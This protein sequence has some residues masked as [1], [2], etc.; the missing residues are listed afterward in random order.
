MSVR[1]LLDTNV[2][3]E[4]ARPRPHAGVMSALEANRA[5]VCTVAVVA[6]EL[7]YGVARLPAG[8]RRRQLEA[9]VDAV[10][11]SSLPVLPY[12][13][14]AAV[15]HA[16]QRAANEV[17]GQ[18]VGFADGIVAAVAAVNGLTVVTRDHTG[19]VAFDVPVISWWS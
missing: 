8:R 14:Q 11:S 3:S 16:D 13:H 2:L 10:L 9:Y 6:H 1:Y 15:W 17:V 7:R 5:V 19:F 12:D 4:G 18:S